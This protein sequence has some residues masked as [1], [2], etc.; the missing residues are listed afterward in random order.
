VLIRFLWR[1]TYER[2]SRVVISRRVSDSYNNLTNLI[3]LFVADAKESPSFDQSLVLQLETVW[4]AASRF[5]N[6]VMPPSGSCRMTSKLATS[7]KTLRSMT[8]KL[9][10]IINRLLLG[11]G[12]A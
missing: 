5:W 1:D 11:E 4:E 7:V 8:A 9:R 12:G 3:P 6:S 2:S 10:G